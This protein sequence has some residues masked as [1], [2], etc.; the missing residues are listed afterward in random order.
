[1]E[2]ARRANALAHLWDDGIRALQI[3]VEVHG[4]P[5]VPREYCLP[6]GFSLGLWVVAVADFYKRG[7][8]T[9]DQLTEIEEIPG[10]T[11]I[12]DLKAL[13]S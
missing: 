5:Y 12:N 6:S 10:W 4:H 1:M 8:L 2:A 3:F 7:R 11:L 13:A 9:P